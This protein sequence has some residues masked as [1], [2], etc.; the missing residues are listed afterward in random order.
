MVNYIVS[1]KIDKKPH[2]GN[3][4][5]RGYLDLVGGIIKR[6]EP[7]IAVCTLLVTMEPNL[8]FVMKLNES[9]IL[10]YIYHIQNK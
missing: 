2:H 4:K 9:T 7:F 6:G 10:D 5:Y 8:K 3:S 1:E